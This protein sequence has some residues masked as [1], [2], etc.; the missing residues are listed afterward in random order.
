M[1][2]AIPPHAMSDDRDALFDVRGRTQARTSMTAWRDS[3]RSGPGVGRLS[4]VSRRRAHL[5]VRHAQGGRSELHRV[6]WTPTLRAPIY[7]YRVGICDSAHASAPESAPSQRR[8]VRRCRLRART[9]CAR[10]SRQSRIR[11]RRCGD[12]SPRP[13]RF[14]DRRRS[15]STIGNVYRRWEEWAD[16]LDGLRRGDRGRRRSIPKR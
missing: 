13:R 10:R 5:R 11:R 9:L 4:D 7:Q 2:E 8:C 14:R 6:S 16:A 15:P 1:V 3:L 12:C